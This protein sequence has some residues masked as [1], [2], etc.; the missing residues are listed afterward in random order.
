[1]S[2]CAGKNLC[3][4]YR[5]KKYCQKVNERKGYDDVCNCRHAVR[6]CDVGPCAFERFCGNAAAP[7]PEELFTEMYGG[8]KCK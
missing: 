1:M 2:M 8:K 4:I 7:T 6:K 5:D 3:K